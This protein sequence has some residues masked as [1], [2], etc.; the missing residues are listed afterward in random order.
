MLLCI[1]NTVFCKF[2]M[3]CIFQS[4]KIWWQTSVQA[5]STDLP[6]FWIISKLIFLRDQNNFCCKPNLNNVDFTLKKKIPLPQNCILLFS[7]K[8]PLFTEWPSYIISFRHLD[9]SRFWRR[10]FVVNLSQ[11]KQKRRNCTSSPPQ[12]FKIYFHMW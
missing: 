12:K 1:D 6:P 4:P 3:V 11:H 5:K 2:H 9:I 10:K 8:F 7:K